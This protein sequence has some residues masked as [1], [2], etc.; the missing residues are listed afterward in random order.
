MI[1]A[2]LILRA[3]ALMLAAPLMATF[4]YAA[5]SASGEFRVYVRGVRVDCT[6]ADDGTLCV[7][8]YDFCAEMTDGEA[9][10]SCDGG[11][12][13]VVC[14]EISVTAAAGEQYVVSNGRCFW[15]GAE[16]ESRGGGLYV[17]VDALAR[18]FGAEAKHDD[19][20]GRVTVGDG[21]EV[22][23]GD[24]YYDKTELFWLSHIIAAESRGEPLYGKIAVGTVV[25][26]RVMSEKYP[27]TV[28]GVIFDMRH[29]VQFAP[30][31]TGSVFR[32]PNEES[33]IAAKLCMDGARI[34]GEPFY[35]CTTEIMSTSWAGKNRTYI[36]TIGNHAFFA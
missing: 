29:G 23:S 26:D 15:C 34:P 19:A 33:I 11:V 24:E 35:F 4:T 1:K 36:A 32:T 21:G 20:R 7:P 17:S 25:Y 27:N 13:T 3:A 9:A 30:A 16:N 12:F 2:R 28:Y 18:A 22:M 6:A 8:L 31:Y 5:D 14:N 10:V